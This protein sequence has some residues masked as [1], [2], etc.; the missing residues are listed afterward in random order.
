MRFYY[1]GISLPV[2]ISYQTFFGF[3]YHGVRTQGLAHPR[4]A[5]CHW[6]HTPPALSNHFV[7]A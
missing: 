5:L 3:G 6:S 7:R 1:K 4:Q 2:T